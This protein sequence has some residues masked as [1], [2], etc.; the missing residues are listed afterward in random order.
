MSYRVFQFLT[1]C[2]VLLSLSACFSEEKAE[3]PKEILQKE[4]YG[5][6]LGVDEKNKMFREFYL[7]GTF[8]FSYNAQFH[9]AGTWEILD[10]NRIKLTYTREEGLWTETGT[11]KDHIMTLEVFKKNRDTTE[12]DRIELRKIYVDKTTA[13]W[14]FVNPVCDLKALENI[15]DQCDGLIYAG[16]L[17]NKRLYVAAQDAATAITWNDG[18]DNT[19]RPE[20]I[21]DFIWQNSSSDNGEKNRYILK[22][23]D[24]S[25]ELKAQRL[26]KPGLFLPA[27]KELDLLYKNREALGKTS[28][29]YWSSTRTGETFN[30]VWTKNFMTGNATAE[31]MNQSFA[32]RCV[33]YD[34]K[35][36]LLK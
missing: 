23:I 25:L 21:P 13:T 1:L 10:D 7:N 2:T 34:W 17:N 26:C 36:D 22:M 8:G 29:Q 20:S 18:S 30:K 28:E 35:S 14:H 16:D 31:N 4:I 9:P 3:S 6:W 19:N 5:R 27:T 12:K 11:I 24:A 32:V 15:G 33:R